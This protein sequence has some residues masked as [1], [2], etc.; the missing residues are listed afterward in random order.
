MIS[1]DRLQEILAESSP[2]CGIYRAAELPDDAVVDVMV[3]MTAK[4]WR[5][6]SP[7]TVERT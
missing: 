3:S 2:S 6:L 1:Y 5:E 4:E 7:E